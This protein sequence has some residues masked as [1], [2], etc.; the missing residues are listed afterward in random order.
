MIININQNNIK[1]DSIRIINFWKKIEYKCKDYTKC[2]SKLFN[3]S[4]LLYYWLR[5]K[6]I[7]VALMGSLLSLFG[8]IKGEVFK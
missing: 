3:L 5:E 8:I 7:E 2:S 6:I 1:I 4:I